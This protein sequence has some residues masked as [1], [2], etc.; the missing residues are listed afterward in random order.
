V[1]SVVGREMEACGKRESQPT[2]RTTL[3]VSP[4]SCHL[5]YGLPARLTLRRSPPSPSHLPFI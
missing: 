2:V 1:V 4:L 3:E 5:G